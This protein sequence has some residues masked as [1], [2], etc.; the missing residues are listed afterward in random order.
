MASVPLARRPVQEARLLLG[1]ER[2]GLRSRSSWALRRAF[3]PAP[4]T[5]AGVHGVA[6]GSGITTD[7][8]GSVGFV[9]VALMTLGR[10][11]L[12]VK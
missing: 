4:P 12:T 8:D 7:S 1:R 11:E 9:N 3:R 6:L 10:G 2:R 5:R